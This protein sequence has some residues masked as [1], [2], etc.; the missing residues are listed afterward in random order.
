MNHEKIKLTD[1]L[2]TDNFPSFITRFVP[3]L[4]FLYE[5]SSLSTPVT[6]PKPVKAVVLPK[7]KDEVRITPYDWRKEVAWAAQA[8]P[9][10]IF[11]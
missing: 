8:A 9:A 6:Q 1:N 3:S 10:V 5:E 11:R 4:Q 2:T 7:R